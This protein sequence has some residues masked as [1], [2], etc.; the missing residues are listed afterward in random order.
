MRYNKLYW[1]IRITACLLIIVVAMPIQAVQIREFPMYHLKDASIA[2][3]DQF[4]PVIY[5]NPQIL[6]TLGPQ[7]S[8]FVRAHEH[9]HHFLQHM[10]REKLS[11]RTTDV[12]KLRRIFEL[13][14]DCYAAKKVARHIAL[15]AAN[16]FSDTQGLR[17]PD[18]NHPTGNER[19][20][21]I[22]QCSKISS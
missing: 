10:H 12:A 5:Y 11:T 13:E 14:A 17:R 1:S 7:I 16:N 19:A 3:Y 20:A 18:K 9:A 22:R 8:E 15:A 6:R 21:V 4:G 2:T